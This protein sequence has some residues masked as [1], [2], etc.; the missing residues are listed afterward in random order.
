[1]APSPAYSRGCDVLLTILR[2]SS[3]RF[4]VVKCQIIGTYSSAL[5]AVDE[6]KRAIYYNEEFREVIVKA[7]AMT[8]RGQ[9]QALKSYA[10]QVICFIDEPILSAFGSSTYVAVRRE[11]VVALLRDMIDAVHADGALAGIHC[12]ANTEWSILID[13]GVDIISF[14]AFQYGKA[15]AMYAEAVKA[16]L[17]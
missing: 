4:P 17:S 9:I 1:M 5:T 7:L 10:D 2:E 8:A 16:Y 3:F 11:D 13:A 6:R 14:D 12:C 15:I